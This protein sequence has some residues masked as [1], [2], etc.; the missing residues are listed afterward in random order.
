MALLKTIR[1][2]NDVV[3][4]Y[5]RI[6]ELLSNFQGEAGA[7]RLVGYVSQETRRQRGVE[8]VCMEREFRIDADD[9]DRLYT[10]HVVLLEQSKAR[11]EGLAAAGE[12][13]QLTAQQLCAALDQ[14]NLYR[15]CY[16]LV[17]SAGTREVRDPETG[18]VTDVIMGEFSGAENLFE[19]LRPQDESDSDE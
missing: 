9:T 14:A 18:E 4:T 11:I 3:A 1:E 8:A 7:V 6:A 2:E 17:K 13:D 19:D 12:I 15:R 16:Q 5:W 10:E